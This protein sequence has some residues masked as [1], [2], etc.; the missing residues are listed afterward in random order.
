M[1]LFWDE[2]LDIELLS[3]GEH[4]VDVMVKEQDKDLKW[5]G[6]F[7][8][9]EP[10]VQDRHLM[11]ERMRML[12]NKSSAPWMMIGDFNE[13]MWSFEHFSHTQRREKQMEDFREVLS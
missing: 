1:W 12:K 5:R 8:Y 6:T 4:H 2:N 13:V 7:V 11:W 3:I 9:E 10:R